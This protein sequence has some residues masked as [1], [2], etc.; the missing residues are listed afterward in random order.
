MYPFL[1]NSTSE[2]KKV[3]TVSAMFESIDTEVCGSNPNVC[4]FP[5][6]ETE[7]INKKVKEWNYK[8]NITNTDQVFEDVK[9]MVEYFSSL[10]NLK[11]QWN[12]YLEEKSNEFNKSSTSE[13]ENLIVSDVDATIHKILTIFEKFFK[14]MEKINRYTKGALLS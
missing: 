13:I 14:T 12:T 8:N 3:A 4:D 5:D 6:N 11:D 7:I 10:I 1:A 2:L 9:E